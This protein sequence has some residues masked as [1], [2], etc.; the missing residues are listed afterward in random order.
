MFFV[1]INMFNRS[2]VTIPDAYNRG[3]L[4]Y[5]SAVQYATYRRTEVAYD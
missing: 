1:G 2:V 3:E 4:K 5:N